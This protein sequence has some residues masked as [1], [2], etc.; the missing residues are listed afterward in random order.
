MKN[1]DRRFLAKSY[2]KPLRF[3][4]SWGCR[5]INENELVNLV[6]THMYYHDRS[7]TQLRHTHSDS[8]QQLMRATLFPYL[9]CLDER[10]MKLL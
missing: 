1:F 7:T 2:K 10:S 4:F 8:L 9:L 3:L 6:L 5:K